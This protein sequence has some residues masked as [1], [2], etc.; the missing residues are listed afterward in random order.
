MPVT[1]GVS[2]A[3]PGRPPRVGIWPLPK[4]SLALADTKMPAAGCPVD[5]RVPAQRVHGEGSP[6]PD[7]RQTRTAA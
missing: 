6:A 2:A 1:Y 5:N 7:P 4:H 3:A